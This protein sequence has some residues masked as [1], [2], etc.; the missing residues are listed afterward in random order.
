M[1]D[2]PFMPNP[3]QFLIEVREKHG[4]EENNS[5]YKREYLGMIEY[6][7]E[8]RIIKRFSTYK[9][10]ALPFIPIEIAIGLDYGQ[11]DKDSLVSVCL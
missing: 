7:T 9:K 11:V 2:N 5:T 6:D 4:W 8:A 10:D 1:L 3:E